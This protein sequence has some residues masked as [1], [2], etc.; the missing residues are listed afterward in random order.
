MSKANDTPRSTED[1]FSE[2][3]AARGE[4]SNDKLAQFLAQGGRIQRPDG[5]EVQ[6]SEVMPTGLA[7]VDGRA[8][9][10][11][12][13]ALRAYCDAEQSRKEILE[14]LGGKAV[15]PKPIVPVVSGDT[16]HVIVPMRAKLS[17]RGKAQQCQIEVYVRVFSEGDRAIYEF[18]GAVGCS[19]RGIE[20]VIWRACGYSPCKGEGDKLEDYR[21]LE[22][23]CRFPD[24][25]REETIS[26]IELSPSLSESLS[27]EGFQWVS[28]DTVLASGDEVSQQ[29]KMVR[30]T[31]WST[32]MSR[33]TAFLLVDDTFTM[34]E[35]RLVYERLLETILEQRN[36]HMKL[37]DS[38][39][40]VREV[41]KNGK[42]RQRY[43]FVL[44]EFLA[45]QAEMRTKE[46]VTFFLNVI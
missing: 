18:P 38:L 26:C 23:G 1:I 7:V 29:L 34:V 41:D 36:F 33:P 9:V 15:E 39:R 2:I 31:M 27:E 44:E 12:A 4:V 45:R 8:V 11:D 24:D 17:K 13:T 16:R 3:F 6:L 20:D 42:E 21:I 46:R 30:H 43:E 22:V 37:R 5:S 28:M 35:I 25:G 14:L 10:R 40:I 19:E 32:F